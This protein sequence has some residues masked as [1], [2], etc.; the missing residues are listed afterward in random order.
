MFLNYGLCTLLFVL[1]TFINAQV[2]LLKLF[3]MKQMK[4]VSNRE[5]MGT[6]MFL[7]F[8]ALGRYNQQNILSL[9]F[10]WFIRCINLLTK[11]FFHY[12][13][14]IDRCTPSFSTLTIFFIS[15]TLRPNN[16][17]FF[18]PLGSFTQNIV[19][20]KKKKTHVPNRA[21]QNIFSLL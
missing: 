17:P 1:C 4:H 20:I 8:N 21:L 10:L 3:C 14:F 2:Y 5:T 7:F 9:Q 15:Q 19:M 6:Y 11:K 13:C 16:N 18:L 12:N